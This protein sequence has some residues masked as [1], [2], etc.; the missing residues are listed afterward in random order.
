MLILDGSNYGHA[1]TKEYAFL[2]L[3]LLTKRNIIYII[4]AY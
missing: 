2:S 3:K 1:L 4:I